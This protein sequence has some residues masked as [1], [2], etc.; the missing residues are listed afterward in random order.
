MYQLVV[1]VVVIRADRKNLLTK[2]PASPHLI[3]Q[4]PAFSNFDVAGRYAERPCRLIGLVTAS[5]G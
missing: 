5:G 4:R 1:I 3:G 2:M